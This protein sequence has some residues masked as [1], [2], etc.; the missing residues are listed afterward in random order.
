VSSRPI[1]YVT[2]E[3]CSICGKP[4]RID[5]PYSICSA[6]WASANYTTPDALRIA[7]VKDREKLAANFGKGK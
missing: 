5:G 1:T 6:C 7:H 2:D 4:G 3:P